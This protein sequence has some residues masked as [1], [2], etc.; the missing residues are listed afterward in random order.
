MILELLCSPY[1]KGQW[2]I[3]RTS[4]YALAKVNE[5]GMPKLRHLS[6]RAAMTGL[7]ISNELQESLTDPQFS[8]IFR[9][10]TLSFWLKDTMKIRYVT[11]EML[12]QRLKSYAG[13]TIAKRKG[14]KRPKIA[15]VFEPDALSSQQPSFVASSNIESGEDI[16]PRAHI[17][18]QEAPPIRPDHYILYKGKANDLYMDPTEGFI[19][20][21]G[22][23]QTRFL[24]TMPGG[25]FNSTEVAYYWMKEKS[26]AE[27]YRQ[28]GI[29]RSEYSESWIIQIQVPKNFID[30]L[31]KEQLWFSRDWKEYVWNCRKGCNDMPEKFDKL[32]KTG[33][34]QLVEGHI[35]ARAPNI[36]PK[37]PKDK[38]QERI[39]ESDV[40]YTE[41]EKATQ[42]VFMNTDT[43]SQ[44]LNLI[45]GKVHIEIYPS[46]KVAD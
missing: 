21:S 3:L 23:M 20:D 10:E 36:I 4:S 11:L 17:S 27:I 22:T 30:S 19:N 26:T 9:S 32:W 25:D 41:G 31:R 39:T 29:K 45:R 38:F 40:L 14:H 44:L 1:S 24:Q 43:F 46:K 12:L 15:G 37:I 28:W 33:R 42:S 7:G 34:A 35:C 6:D 8:Q 5:L 13:E 2:L 16:L 18:I